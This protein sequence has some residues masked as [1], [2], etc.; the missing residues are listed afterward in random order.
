[1]AI[2][3][4]GAF[5]TLC[6]LGNWQVQRLEWKEALI[7]QIDQRMAAAP[8]SIGEMQTIQKNGKD[9]DYRPVMVTGTFDHDNEAYYYNT[10]NG[11]V[12]WNVFTPLK[13]DSGLVVLVNR[14]FVPEVFREPAARAKGQVTGIQSITGLARTPPAEKPNSF[15][16]ENDI[17]AN[18]FFWKD[19]PAMAAKMGQ[20]RGE[21][22]P[23]FIDAGKSQTP[24]GYPKGGTTRVSFPN[25]HLQY[26]VTWYGLAFGLVLVSG[27]FLWS[28]RKSKT[29]TK[30]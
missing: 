4:I 25:N 24:G 26:A 1:M 2:L 16:P 10:N 22:T 18:I 8:V 5:I 3:V 7:A 15:M 14:G 9:V 27:F 12:G 30:A 21:V 29:H 23:F 17:A 13:T 6:F 28:N 19:L 20:G 11:V